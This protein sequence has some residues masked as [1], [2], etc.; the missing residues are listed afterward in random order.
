[1][2]AKLVAYSF[3]EMLFKT[4]KPILQADNKEFEQIAIL[5]LRKM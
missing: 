4:W 5:A 1:M 2:I 3:H